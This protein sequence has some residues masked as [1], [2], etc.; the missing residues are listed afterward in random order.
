M[1][2]YNINQIRR[3]EQGLEDVEA[4]QMQRHGVVDDRE[5]HFY[6]RGQRIE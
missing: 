4:F 6:L 3:K 2:D 5:E 1:L